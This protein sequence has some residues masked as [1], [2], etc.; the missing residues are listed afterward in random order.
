[1]TIWS[2]L[3]NALGQQSH[4]LRRD[5]T[6]YRVCDTVARTVAGRPVSPRTILL[7][8]SPH[9]NELIHKHPLAG[10]TGIVVFDKLI[11]DP[12]VDL[13]RCPASPI[14]CLLVNSQ[15]RILDS[16]G[17]MNVSELPLQRKAYSCSL[18]PTYR[19]LFDP[20]G[21][22]TKTKDVR[23]T[24]RI[25]GEPVWRAIGNDL[26]RRLRA[27]EDDVELVP[28]G[29]VARGYLRWATDTYASLA[30]LQTYRPVVYHPSRWHRRDQ[31]NSIRALIAHIVDRASS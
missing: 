28:C 14:G 30:S 27:L 1:M 24:N 19:N 25:D 12:R 31:Q 20:F 17:L 4:E 22:I 23:I 26:C 9:T 2:E 18:H 21:K 7:C 13:R 10:D 6:N 8:E 29:R 11:D 5:L 16:I 3:G 15:H